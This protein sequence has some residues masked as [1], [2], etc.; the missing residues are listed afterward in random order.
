MIKNNICENCNHLLVCKIAD[1]LAPFHEEAKKDLG[2]TITIN[3]C[4]EFLEA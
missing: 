2:V 4:E 3:S 1:K